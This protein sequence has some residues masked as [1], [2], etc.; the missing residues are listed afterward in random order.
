MVML[1]TALVT[2][3]FNLLFFPGTALLGASGVV[4][5]MVLLCSF[6]GSTAEKKIPLTFLLVAVLYLGQQIYQAF[7]ADNISQMAHI[8]GGIVGS[9]FGFLLNRPKSPRHPGHHH[10]VPPG[11][12]PLR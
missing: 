12:A 6:T 5:A 3:I 8:V 11:D 9:G 10:H 7:S 1:V 2:G 4:F